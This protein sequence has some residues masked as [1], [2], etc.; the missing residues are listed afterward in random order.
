MHD[1]LV[2]VKHATASV[3]VFCEFPANGLAARAD[4]APDLRPA[5]DPGRSCRA[6]SESQQQAALREVGEET[7]L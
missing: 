7:G 5:H 3:F 4:P 2:T 1:D 6:G